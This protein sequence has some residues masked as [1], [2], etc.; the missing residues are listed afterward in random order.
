MSHVAPVTPQAALLRVLIN[1][2]S[3]GT[4]LVRKIRDWTEGQ[5][6]LDE[7][8]LE[9]AV[10]ELESSGLIERRQGAPDKRTGQVHVT[11]ALTPAGQASAREILAESLTRKT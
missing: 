2:E 3:D 4:D 9:A 10:R 6:E 11:F 7:P 5:V 8:G 1:G